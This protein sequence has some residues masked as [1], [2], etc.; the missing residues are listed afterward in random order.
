MGVAGL[1]VSA[2]KAQRRLGRPGISV[3]C[4]QSDSTV[5]DLVAAGAVPHDYVRVSTAG[6]IRQA[7]FELRRHGKWPHCTVDVSPEG[8]D[9]SVRRLVECFDDAQP[10]PRFGRGGAR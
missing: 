7:G 5:A 6:R 3:F 10:N 9:A 8:T 2:A 4:G 1:L